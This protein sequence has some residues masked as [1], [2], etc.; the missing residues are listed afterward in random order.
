M[1]LVSSA[2]A[3]VLEMYK[4]FLKKQYRNNKIL[5]EIDFKNG[6]HFK[7]ILNVYIGNEDEKDFAELNELNIKSK[8][9]LILIL[10]PKY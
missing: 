9:L 10:N 7:E 4:N 3:I 2:R 8:L 6:L 5:Q 1:Y